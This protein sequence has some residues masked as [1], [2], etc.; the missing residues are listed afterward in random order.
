MTVNEAL[1]RGLTE[2][3]TVRLAQLSKRYPVEVVPASE[4]RA[5]Q[6]STADDARK[7]LGVN[8]VVEGS[9]DFGANNQV[10]YSLVDASNRRNLDAAVVH[11]DLHNLLGAER[12][13]VDKLLRMLQV[14]LSPEERKAA[15]EE[16][17]RPDA[18][19]YYVRGRGYLLNYANPDNLKSAV[20]LFKTA[21]DTDPKF[22]L[23]YAG[24]AEAYWTQFQENKDQ[25]FVPKATEAC[26]TAARLNN[27][28]APVH[29][30]FGLI[31]QGTGRYEDAVR[32]FARAIELDPT[33]DAAYRGL[34]SSYASMG[35]MHEAEDAYRR[36]ISMRKDY[37]GGYS[38]LGAFYYNAGRY[39]EAAAQ[40]RRVIELVPENARGYTNLGGIFY[41]QGKYQQAQEL[42]EKSLSLQPNYRAYSN[43]GTLYFFQAR[44]SDAARMFEKALQVN[45]K[46]PRLWQY[47]AAAYYWAPGE[48]DKA[49]AA[50]QKAAL[51]ME[52]E[53]KLNPRDSKLM[54]ALADC[55]SMLG[56]RHRAVEP[57]EVALALHAGLGD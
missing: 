28:L 1:C 25:A 19:Q 7:K 9:W 43:L 10:M 54:L 33:S 34:A 14:E 31:Y 42:F 2:L 20:A 11:A 8:L 44:Y 3:L 22:A 38:A 35:K 30:T 15:G 55:E 5:Q 18:Y 26:R 6:V 48:R 49:R 36:A 32:E 4:I 45:D 17:S 13:V 37:W 27:R 23:A 39:D 21:I 16:I 53:L 46:D 57:Q 24:L 40:F 47:V 41:F 12:E 56:R 50:Y 52:K 51:M 29:V